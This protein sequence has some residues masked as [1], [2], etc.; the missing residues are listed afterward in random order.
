MGKSLSAPRL[1]DPSMVR[2]IGNALGPMSILE[3]ERKAR[4]TLSDGTGREALD[5]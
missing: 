5:V 1:D 4:H 2:Y 3:K